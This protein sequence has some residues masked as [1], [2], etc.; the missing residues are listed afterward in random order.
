MVVSIP[1]HTYR[2]RHGGF[3]FRLVIPVRLRQY[4]N[5]TEVRFSLRTE[6]RQEAIM[7]AASIIAAR[8]H[9]FCE[10][11]RMAD[12][13]EPIP[14]DFFE[15]WIAE[16]HLNGLLRAKIKNLEDENADLRATTVPIAKA[17]TVAKFMRDKGVMHGKEEAFATMIFPWPPE[18]TVAISELRDAYL[19]GLANRP[20]GGRRKPPTEKTMAEYTATINLFLTVMGDC[21]IGAIDNEIAGAYFQII[22]RLPANMNKI[23]AYKGKT[24][25][26][27][28]ALNATP[29]DEQTCSKKMER[30]STMF[31]WALKEKRKWGIDANPFEGFGQAPDTTTKTRQFT[32]DELRTL[33]SHPT[34]QN[35]QF[36]SSYSYWL[37]PMALFTGARLGELCQLDLK[38]FVTID[39]VDC[40]DINDIDAT[41]ESIEGGAKKRVKTKNARRLVPLH[42]TLKDIGL[43]RYVDALRHKGE[44]YLFPELSRKGRD[45]PG[46]VAS[47][48][49]QRFR[50]K[51]GVTGKRDTVFHSFR[52]Y[53]I[54]KL[55][56]SKVPPHL[57][58]P[59]VGHEGKLITD[60]VYWGKRDAKERLPTVEKFA[61]AADICKMIPSCEDV[62]LFAITSD[63]YGNR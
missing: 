48:W 18:R 16:L 12:S 44:I 49:F 27:L 55:L 31:N 52:H 46:Q 58:A 50:D 21:R 19:R 10:L 23:A 6:Q 5:R 25:P 42:Q 54:T 3:Y 40:I 61:L 41:E 34:F 13:D 62:S 63:H 37:I 11:Q 35:R 24:I 9:L 1:S 36:R 51:A 38:D 33:L 8:Q 29:Q 26:E 30:L 39:G 20:D 15:K 2:N 17:K 53:F 56:D 60:T 59:I 4:V 45:G 14:A 43:L 47:K 22:K 32:N 7:T 57:V 28:L